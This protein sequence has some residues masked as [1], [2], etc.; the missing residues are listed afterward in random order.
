M[1]CYFKVICLQDINNREKC[2]KIDSIVFGYSWYS[3]AIFYKRDDFNS[4]CLPFCKLSPFQKGF[5]CNCKWKECVP[6]RSEFLSYRLKTNLNKLFPLRVGPFSRKAATI[7]TYLLPQKCYLFPLKVIIL[8]YPAGT[9]SWNNIK[10][11]LIQR[12]TSN[13]RWI[14]VV[15]TFWACWVFTI[16]ILLRKTNV[17][18]QIFPASECAVQSRSTSFIKTFV[19]PK[20]WLQNSKN[21]F[22]QDDSNDRHY[23]DFQIYWCLLL[24]YLFSITKDRKI[25]RELFWAVFVYVYCSVIYI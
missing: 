15:S 2:A 22:Y 9:Q 8:V 12:L 10:S 20:Y 3:T 25:V 1:V 4:S 13:Q 7:L 17:W 19:E 23:W 11:K 24:R 16:K 21:L 14:D 18:L 6:R 5:T